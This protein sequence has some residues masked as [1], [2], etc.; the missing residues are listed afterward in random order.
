MAHEYCHFLVDIGSKTL[1]DILGAP[2]YGPWRE[3]LY[4]QRL[5]YDFLEEALA[6]A[7]AYRR[8]KIRGLAAPTRDFLKRSPAGYRDFDAYV[9]DDAWAQGLRDL[10]SD[11]ESCSNDTDGNPGRWGRELLIDQ[12]QRLV[13]P[14]NVP[15]WLVRPS[16]RPVWLHLVTSLGPVASTGRYRRDMKRLPANARAQIE[17]DI[18]AAQRG[19]TP[20]KLKRLTGYDDRYR[21]RS[22]NYRV[23]LDLDSDG[24]FTAIG[25]GHRRNVYKGLPA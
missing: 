18:D 13:S 7:F 24:R 22:G 5:P 14:L 6:N 21:L 10:M 15:V 1:E 8:G 25:V 17:K 12:D 2:L 20:K 23:I 9:T 19:V 16:D 11:L 3:A 4:R